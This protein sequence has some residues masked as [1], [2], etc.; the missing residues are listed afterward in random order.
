MAPSLAQ[1]GAIRAG[2]QLAARALGFIQIAFDQHN[3]RACV[4]RDTHATARERCE[5]LLGRLSDGFFFLAL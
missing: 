5:L 2:S 4:A 1:R 3:R